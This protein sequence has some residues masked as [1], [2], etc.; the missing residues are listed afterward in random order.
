[1]HTDT[2]YNQQTET[3]KLRQRLIA[4]WALA[5][6]FLG[7]ILHGLH[8]PLT[9]LII[10]SV[11]VCCLALLAYSGGKRSDLIKATLLVMLVKAML[12]PHSPP[13]AYFAVFMQG[14]LASLLFRGKS[15]FKLKCLVLAVTTQILS[16]VQHMVILLIVF[17]K[18]FF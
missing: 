2:L 15:Q 18:T 11:S 5:E 4:S 16:A 12:S 7:G 17:G 9:G 8:L 13:A 10:G 3:V 14:F 6:G 1:M